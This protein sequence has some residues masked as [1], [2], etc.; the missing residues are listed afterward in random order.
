M[1]GTV[2]REEVDKRK[3]PRQLASHSYRDHLVAGSMKDRNF[4]LR[5]SFSNFPDAGAVII[6]FD[7]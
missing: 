5:I 7:Q 6:A 1:I 4:R 2:D 3:I